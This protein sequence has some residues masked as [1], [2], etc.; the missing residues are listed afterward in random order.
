MGVVTSHQKSSYCYAFIFSRKILLDFHFGPMT[1]LISGS[2][3]PQH[4][5]VRVLAHALGFIPNLKKKKWL[6]ATIASVPLLQQDNLKTG[7]SLLQIRICSGVTLKIVSLI[8]QHEKCF[9]AWGVLEVTD[10]LLRSLV[11]KYNNF[12]F[13]ATKDGKKVEAIR[14]DLGNT[15]L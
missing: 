7:Q 10:F 15:F 8:Q 4:C 6:V 14:D 1:Y 2:W 9:P 13:I 3:S 5:Q 12:L 11:C